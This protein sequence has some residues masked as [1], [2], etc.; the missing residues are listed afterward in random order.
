MAAVANSAVSYLGV[1]LRQLYVAASLAT[2]VADLSAWDT[3]KYAKSKKKATQ[4]KCHF[5]KDKTN[6][7]CI[8]CRRHL[9]NIP[10]QKRMDIEGGNI[11][12]ISVSLRTN[13]NLIEASNVVKI[14]KSSWR[15][16]L[17]IWYAGTSYTVMVGRMISWQKQHRL[18]YWKRPN[19]LRYWKRARVWIWIQR[20]TKIGNK[21]HKSAKSTSTEWWGD[22]IYIDHLH[23]GSIITTRLHLIIH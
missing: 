19:C 15:R 21:K 22:L 12:N 4:Q 14:T 20:A 9:C 13:L 10:P 1:P 5:C 8:G 2:L 6:N 17:D 7:Y 23:R 3:R 11:Q 16:S 18:L